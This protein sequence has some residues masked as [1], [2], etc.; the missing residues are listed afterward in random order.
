MRVKLRHVFLGVFLLGFFQVL[1]GCSSS[2]EQQ[3]ELI[4]A[5]GEEVSEEAPVEGQGNY[6]GEEGGNYAGEEGGNYAAEEG[7]EGGYEGEEGGYEEGGNYAA[8]EGAEAGYEGEEGGNYAA[9]EGEG[10]GDLQEI[11]DEMNQNGAATEEVAAADP[12]MEGVDA[13][14]VLAGGEAAVPVEGTE[15]ISTD[16]MAAPVAEAA[17]MDPAAAPVADASMAAPVS[18]AG[19]PEMNSKMSYVVQ[20]GDSL[21]KIAQ[22]IYGD[23]SKWREMAELSGLENPSWIYP[24][25]VVYYRLTEQSMAFAGTYENVARAEVTVQAGDTLS[26]IASRV[27]GDSSSWKSIWRENDNIN[28]PDQLEVGSV[29]YYIA[30]GTLTAALKASKAQFAVSKI[31]IKK[32]DSVESKVVS[33][34]SAKIAKDKAVVGVKTYRSIHV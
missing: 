2:Q 10:Q 4:E 26:T 15:N 1:S 13:D 32:L 22:R 5:E 34:A 12:A 18:S 3:E 28:N 24:G 17:P 9:E 6:A 23:M 33:L 19:L 7:A 30:P 14:A 16:G 11:I 31:E 25:D 27:L 29:V 8:E 20:K 21:A